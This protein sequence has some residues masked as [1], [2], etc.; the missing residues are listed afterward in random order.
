MVRAISMRLTWTLREAIEAE[1]AC[2]AAAMAARTGSNI[3]RGS[4]HPAHC[5]GAA[6]AAKIK[7]AADGGMWRAS[8]NK[9]NEYRLFNPQPFSGSIKVKE[10]YAEIGVP[11][12]EDG[13]FS[14]LDLNAAV[15]YADYSTNGLSRAI[16]SAAH[17]P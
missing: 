4:G 8:S 13:I 16:L 5:A 15:R 12:I 2:F 10:A 6:G 11:L 14:L 17:L 7:T 1:I 9:H 3:H